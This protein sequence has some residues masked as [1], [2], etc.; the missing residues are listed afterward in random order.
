MCRDLRNF[1]TK[2]GLSYAPDSSGGWGGVRLSQPKRGQGLLPKKSRGKLSAL[3]RMADRAAQAHGHLAASQSY[4]RAG[5]NAFRPQRG[6]I[7]SGANQIAQLTRS[8]NG[9][10][11]SIGRLNAVSSYLKQRAGRGRR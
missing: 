10:R 8:I 4:T 7:N 6:A 3:G 5:V 2:S 1:E 11:A 9:S